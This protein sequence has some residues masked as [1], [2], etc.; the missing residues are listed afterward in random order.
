MRRFRRRRGATRSLGP[1]RARLRDG[2]AESQQ[3]RRRALLGLAAVAL[4]LAVLGARFVFLQVIGYDEYHTRSERNRIKPRPIVPARGL[5]Y[6]RNGVLLADN[7]P[8]YRLELVPEQVEDMQA[9]LDALAA[10]LPITPDERERF[11]ALR[12]GRRG[13]QPVPLKLRL[14][15]AEVARF[16]VERHRFPGVDVVPYLTR[17]YPAGAL[18]AHV[19]GY[20]GRIDSRDLERLDPVQYR[21]STHVGKS[22]IERYYENRLHGRVGYEEVETNAEGRVLRVLKRTPA[23]AGEHLY[24]SVDA[25]LQALATAAFAG[26]PGSAV[27]IDPRSGEVLALVNVPSF[28][29]NAFVAGMS[30]EQYAALLDAPHRPLFNR[31]VLGGYGPGSTLKPFIGL[32]GLEAGLRRASDRIFSG[33][34]FRLPGQEHEYRDWRKGGHGWVDLRESIAQSVN[35][36]FYPLALDLGIDDLGQAM[37]RFGFGAP[38]GIDLTGEASGVLPSREWKRARFNQPWYPGETVISG[39]GQ[40]YWVTTPLQLAHA[41]SILAAGGDVHPPH[42]LRASRAGFDA[43]IEAAPRP[44]ASRALAPDSPH[45]AVVVDGM[46]AVMH[47]ETGTARAYAQDAP[48]RIAGKTGTAQRI[49]R[50]GE[51]SLDPERL[52]EHLR[53]Q[54]LF[55]G[56]APAEDPRIAIAVVVEHG[57]SGTR[58]A[59]PI[60]RRIFDAW[61]LREDAWSSP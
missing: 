38:T 10:V 55:I 17:H 40:G 20:V 16:A 8:A 15:E 22:G 3:F 33:G 21:E 59:A 34:A 23:V 44:P 43:T 27:A 36:Y 37:A 53:H 13:F 29:P 31:A 5:V 9:T 50:S 58:A 61:L 35:T 47:G 19:V 32:A 12:T 49:G 39:I 41:T 14:S 56:F 28:D 11:A 30:R 4:A 1:A 52:A 48:Y 26:Q 60:A 18:F 24:L 57:G 46:V 54:A 51:Q 25:E 7:V 42:L 6:D 2:L 45:L